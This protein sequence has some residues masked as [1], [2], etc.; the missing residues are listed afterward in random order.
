[1]SKESFEKEMDRLIDDMDSH[2]LDAQLAHEAGE[3]D[4]L[5]A[6]VERLKGVCV[7]MIDLLDGIEPFQEAPIHVGRER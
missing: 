5:R 1:M 7:A 2:Y 6:E 3:A 4:D